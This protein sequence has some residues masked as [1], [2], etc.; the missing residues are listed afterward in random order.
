ME[1]HFLVELGNN[2][3][4]GYIEVW[5]TEPDTYD[6]HMILDT[7]IFQMDRPDFLYNEKE[8]EILV[9]KEVRKIVEKRDLWLLENGYKKTM[10]YEWPTNIEW[11]QRYV[12]SVGFRVDF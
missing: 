4:E 10:N 8:V 3:I 2:K 7:A 11:E 6:D 5:Y 9:E 12:H 1:K